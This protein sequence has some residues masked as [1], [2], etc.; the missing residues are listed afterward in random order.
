MSSR[1]A[2]GPSSRVADKMSQICR[3]DT[4]G[5]RDCGYSEKNCVRPSI[6]LTARD[7]PFRVSLVRA[8]ARLLR[9]RPPAACMTLPSSSYN[10]FIFE[11]RV[12][13][14]T[15]SSHSVNAQLDNQNA[16]DSGGN[17]ANGISAMQVYVNQ[18]R[19]VDDR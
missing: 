4:T 5:A 15:T 17:N 11:N 10:P 1:I 18:V 8:T 3:I 6:L 12:P 16:V 13:N 14:T 2:R 9:V 19:S 7:Q